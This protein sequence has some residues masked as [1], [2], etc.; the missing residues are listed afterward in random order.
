MVIFTP[1][2]NSDV[3]YIVSLAFYNLKIS[4]NL[5]S[6][7]IFTFFLKLSSLVSYSSVI[8]SVQNKI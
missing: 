3:R 5:V 4:L 2:I 6:F 8:H 7:D 1:Q